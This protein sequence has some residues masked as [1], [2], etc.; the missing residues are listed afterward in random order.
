MNPQ[1]LV[2][3]ALKVSILL[4]VFGFGLEATRDDLLYMLRRPSALARS[5]TAMFVIMPLFALLLTTVFRFQRPVMIALIALA[6]SPVPPLLPRRVGKAGGARSYGLG[7]M[8]AAASLSVLYIPLA[9]RLIGQ[10]VHKPLAMDPAPVAKLIALSVLV[11]LAV[12]ILF[13]RLAPSV[14][15]RIAKPTGLVA[16]VLLTVSL[17]A[18]LIVAFPKSLALIGNGTLPALAAFIIFGL[19]VGNSLGGPGS[20]ERL[21]L[22]LSTACRHPGLALALA[23][24]NIPQ[25]RNVSSAILLYLVLSLIITALYIFWRRRKEMRKEIA[26][27]SSHLVA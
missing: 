3:L 7:L 16:K 21:T 18:T 8:V 14:A 6:I 17:L 13:Q 22:A 10:Y 12:G 9:V 11:P 2:G 26:Q 23:A 5:L 20:D 1:E 27:D 24:A 19:V 4:T 15:A 25:E